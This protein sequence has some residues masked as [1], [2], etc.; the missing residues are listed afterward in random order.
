MSEGH[1]RELRTFHPGAHLIRL[2]DD[3]SLLR[4]Q[5]GTYQPEDLRC[6]G[7]RNFK[8]KVIKRTNR[9]EMEAVQSTHIEEQK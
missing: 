4:K 8:T 5:I 7:T 6:Q 2:I 9:I 3:V 1:N